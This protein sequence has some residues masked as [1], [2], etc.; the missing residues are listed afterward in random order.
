MSKNH[1]YEQSY[2]REN[3]DSNDVFKTG[4]KP[5]KNLQSYTSATF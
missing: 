2:K 4:P 1:I 3:N 5:C